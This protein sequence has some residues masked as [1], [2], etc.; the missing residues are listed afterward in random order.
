MD[1]DG[2]AD[3]VVASQSRGAI[4]EIYLNDGHG[5]FASTE[6]TFPVTSDPNP[7][8]NFGIVLRDF[9]KDGRLDIATADAWRGVSVYT[10][11]PGGD[12]SLSQTILVPAVNE[13]K[14]IDAADI[15]LDGDDDLVF[16]GHNGDPD[17]AD[18]VYLNNGSG[19]FTDSGQRIGDDVTWDTVF[20]DLDNDGDPD[21]VSVN[22]YR[23]NPAKVHI[24][25]GRGVF[26]NS[27]PLPTTQDDDSYDVKLADLDLDGLLE[28]VVADSFD[29]VHSSTSKIFRNGGAAGFE[30][31]E[32]LLSPA[33]SEAKSVD[34]VDLTNDG[35]PDIVLGNWN[36][37]DD[38]CRGDGQG[39]F[40]RETLEGL[41]AQTVAIAAADFDGDGR[42]D[43]VT[44]DALSGTYTV[45]L[46]NEDSLARN[47]P[48]APPSALHAASRDARVRLSWA[49]GSDSITPPNGLTYNV[50]VGT[51]PGKSDVVSGCAANGPGQVHV[52]FRDLRLPAT[53]TFYWS[54]QTVDGS[55]A[56]ST[57]SSE[58]TFTMTRLARTSSSSIVSYG[59]TY[60]FTGNLTSNSRP[61]AGQRVFLERSADG[62]FFY[63]T[64]IAATTTATGTFSLSAKPTARTWY[65]ARF[66][67]TA[68]H[69]GSVSTAAVV[70]VRAYVGTPVAPS[71]MYRTRYYPVYGYL[72]PRHT[73]GTYPMRIY[74]YRYVSGRWRSY[75]Y[76]KAKAYDYSSYTKSKVL[77]KLPYGGRWR[78][79]AYHPADSGHLAS[80]SRGYDYVTVR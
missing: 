22:R 46:N 11:S 17:R 21:Y 10:N 41:P 74:K 51:G 55:F 8:W 36:G 69:I 43:V 59:A 38:L 14:G 79:R 33:G 42:I 77:V 7:L 71:A 64:T 54:V 67:G 65:R 24:N 29:P 60:Y 3:I 28:V 63:A 78:L 49:P 18:R 26:S 6:D 68:T 31:M 15:D 23:E 80:W 72:K 66:S 20:G 57:W 70:S 73:P 12:F 45:H 35:V 39:G 50:R 1:S 37:G 47:A 76:V 56:R 16:G 19:R 58:A 5:S 27:A 40:I 44:G 52:L 53:G 48:P 30:L 2:D 4:I 75:G 34:V 62:T 9:D 13:V 32:G 25:N 61:L